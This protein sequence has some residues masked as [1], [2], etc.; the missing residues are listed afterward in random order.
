MILT[1]WL[2]KTRVGTYNLFQCIPF[3]CYAIVHGIIVY[4]KNSKHK[5]KKKN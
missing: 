1:I 5:S 4:K 2:C 3:A